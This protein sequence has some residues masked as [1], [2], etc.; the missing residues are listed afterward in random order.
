MMHAP[1]HVDAID[2]EVP[3]PGAAHAHNDLPSIGWHR[4]RRLEPCQRGRH[5]WA[6]GERPELGHITC[7]PMPDVGVHG[8]EDAP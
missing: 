4:E 8:T 1:S 5:A 7:K 6:L 2:V 3:T